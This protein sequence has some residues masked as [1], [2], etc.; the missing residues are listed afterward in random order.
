MSSPTL[1][2][3]RTES[4]RVYQTGGPR[5]V[6]LLSLLCLA[7]FFDYADRF[8]LSAVLPFIKRDWGLSDQALGLLSGVLSIPMAVLVVPLAVAVDRWSRKKMLAIM[9]FFWSLATLACAF[10]QNFT[11]LLVARA[12]TGVG[13][14]G[15]AP[16][17]IASIAAAFSRKTRARIT[18]IWDAFAPLGSAVGFIAGGYIG[19]K[20]GWRHAFGVMAIPGMILAFCFLFTRDYQTVSL[21]KT[22][23]DGTVQTARLWDS[24][25]GLFR[26]PTLRYVWLGFAM[27][28]AV[29]TSMMSWLPSYFHRFHGMN[30]QQAGNFAGMLALLVLVGAPAGGIIADRWMRKRP[31][32]RMRLSGISSLLSMAALLGALFF[33]QT[34]AFKPLL[35]TFGIFSVAFLAPGAAVIQDV[36]HPGLRA[37]AYGMNVLVLQLL[38]ASWTPWLVGKLSDTWNLEKALMVLPLFGLVA[39]FLFLYGARHYEADLEK[40]ER[41]EMFEE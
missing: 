32:A 22:A 10:T 11:Q 37:L 13:E 6:F 30:E 24:F 27:N 26:I 38:G 1:E 16:A 5:S 2:G 12:L 33:S 8:I 7:F 25:L 9:V 29:N 41:V 14:A 21:D 36:V 4:A 3:P 15:Y 17:A 39:G 18:G 34:V 31:D 40:V 20:Y 35:I 19:L 23:S 28:F